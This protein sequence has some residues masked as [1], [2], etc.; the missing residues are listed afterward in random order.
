MELQ[1]GIFIISMFFFRNNSNYRVK[2]FTAAQIP[3]IDGRE[4]PPE[5]SGDLYPTGIPIYSESELTYLIKTLEIHDCVFSYSDVSYKHVMRIGAEVEAAGANFMLL[6]LNE[7]M[8]KSRKPVIAVGAVRTGCGKSQTS[9]KIIE[10]LSSRNIKVVA[11]RHPMPY[12][13]LKTQKVQR[14]RALSDL[15]KIQ[16]HC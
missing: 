16:L 15:E 10:I 14:F 12:G 4:Y 3:D 5:L 11:V 1:E 2:A 13:N 8:I 9:R 6:G 7:T